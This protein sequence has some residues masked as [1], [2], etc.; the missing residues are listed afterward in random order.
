MCIYIYIERVPP[1]ECLS[2]RL[3]M[4]NTH[5]LEPTL[6]E[7]CFEILFHTPTQKRAQPPKIPLPVAAIP[8]TS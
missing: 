3:C 5:N 8:M 6:R 2:Y 7:A 4:P 1:W